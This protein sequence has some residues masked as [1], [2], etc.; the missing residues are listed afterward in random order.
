[1]LATSRE[2]LHLPGEL[3]YSL[4]A[5]PLPDP[6]ADAHSIARSDAVQLFLE[7]VHQ[8]RPHFDLQEERARSVA[9]I[10]VRLDGIP[11]ALELAAARV[12]VLPVEQIVRL[13]DQRFRLLTSGNRELPRH[14]TLRAMI[15]WSYEL[16]DDAEKALFARLSV[17]AGGWTLAAA[18]DVC[19]GEPIAKDEVVYVLIGLIE[20]SLVVADEDGDRYRMLETLRDYAKEKL[21]AS[22]G[23]DQVRHRHLDYFL[24]FAE[25]AAPRLAGP[26]TTARLQGLEQEHDNMRSSL[27]W[28]LNEVGSPV[29]LRLCA[30]LHNFWLFRGHVAEGREWCTRI[31]ATE[32]A[33]A[34]TLEYAKALHTAGTLAY[35]QSDYR[36]ARALL[37]DSLAICR[38]RG[39]REGIARSL[40]NL[41]N[42]VQDQG[43]YAAARAFY[44]ECLPIAR[45]L[46]NRR[47]IAALLHNL[48][49]VADELGDHSAVRALYEES[50]SI[51]QELGDQAGISATL[52]TLGDLADRD[53][54]F[55]SARA[56]Y[57][58]GLAIS[59]E[60]RDQRG[61]ARCLLGLGGVARE[62]GDSSTSW[63]L[64]KA[65]LAIFRELG[66][67]LPIAL[68]LEGLAAS[69]A[70]RDSSLRAAGIW[71]AAE[72]LREEIGS[73][74]SPSELSSYDRHVAAARAA[75]GDNA[76]FDRAWQEGRTMTLEQAMELTM[77]EA[78]GK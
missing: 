44:E 34:R 76:A 54:D 4:G 21:G 45:E 15:D 17:F 41:G 58:A 49:D 66:D 22:G 31:L 5:L 52:C 3:A 12:A 71:G 16:L 57:E 55:A 63:G 23:A 50:M 72:R 9:E 20:Q 46:R 11:L 25:E 8:Q 43:D 35:F 7:R 65:A 36:S 32:V 75:F 39:D 74:M 56:M 60:L 48:A 62:L 70:V 42:V 29:G 61:I 33:P 10:C 13:L 37:E 51:M 18:V 73:R 69:A 38:E 24:A 53:H 59:R 26:E 77:E 30:A 47:G 68:S 64:S 78:L 28:S 27:E 6:E 2:P 19:G 67:R 14:Q 1:V 40:N